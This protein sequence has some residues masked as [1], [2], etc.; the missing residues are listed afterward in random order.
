MLIDKTLIARLLNE[1]LD[2]DDCKARWPATD[3]IQCHLVTGTA[4]TYMLGVEDIAKCSNTA[5]VI[6]SLLEEVRQFDPPALV[7]RCV[8]MLFQMNGDTEE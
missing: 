3:P 1:L 2:R 8:T 4:E 5:P 7:V 6:D